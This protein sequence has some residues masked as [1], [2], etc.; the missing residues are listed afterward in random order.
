M[1]PNEVGLNA[2]N[3][4]DVTTATRAGALA[5]VEAEVEA[6]RTGADRAIVGPPRVGFDAMEFLIV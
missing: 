1:N 4:A 5:E 2:V 3:E 6:E